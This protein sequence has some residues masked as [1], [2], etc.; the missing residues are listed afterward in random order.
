MGKTRRKSEATILRAFG[1]RLAAVR[2]SRGM[3]QE[4][5]AGLCD[6]SRS[7]LAGVETGRHNLGVAKVVRIAE[8]MGV[9]PSALIE[10]LT[11]AKK[12]R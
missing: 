8:A 4:I 6:M 1:T 9:K 7:Y 2:E 11:P 5:V 10:D 3:T 12:R